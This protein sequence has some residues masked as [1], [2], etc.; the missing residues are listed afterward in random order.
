MKIDHTTLHKI[1][2]LARVEIDP[3]QE[4]GLIKDLE[5]I[6]SWVEKLDELDTE[7]VEPLTHMTM[8]KNA[9]REDEAAKTLTKDEVL[10][11]APDKTNDFFKVPKVLD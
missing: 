10:K 9:M 7:F 3:D 4:E 2:H 6:V 8:E 11:N 5:Q 1:A